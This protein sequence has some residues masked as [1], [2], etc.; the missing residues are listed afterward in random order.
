[1][2]PRFRRHLKIR[3]RRLSKE[4]GVICLKTGQ[5]DI[6]PRA[7]PKKRLETIMHEALHEAAP[8]WTEKQMRIV[9]RALRDALWK[10]GYRRK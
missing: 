6:D 1:M 4:W 10:D 9:T 5:I 2:K 7:T 3:E 8:H